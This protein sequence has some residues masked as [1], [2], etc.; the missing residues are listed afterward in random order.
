[1][2]E[3]VLYDIE[4]RPV[5]EQKAAYPGSRMNFDISTLPAGHYVLSLQTDDG[6]EN[7]VIQ[8]SE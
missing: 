3:F 6:A 7:V 5:M 1:M 8:K 4:G 2:L